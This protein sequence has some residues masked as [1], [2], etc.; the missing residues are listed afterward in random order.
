MDIQPEIQLI[1]WTLLPHFLREGIE[2]FPFDTTQSAQ[3]FSDLLIAR[4]QCIL[5]QAPSLNDSSITITKFVD[6][7]LTEMVNMDNESL[8]IIIHPFTYNIIII[9]TA[10]AKYA[11]ICFLN[12]FRITRPNF[13]LATYEILQSYDVP[14]NALQHLLQVDLCHGGEHDPTRPGP[15]R[16]PWNVKP[17]ELGWTSSLDDAL[18]T[19]NLNV[20]LQIY[21]LIF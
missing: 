1:D 14:N 12:N 17:H 8:S 3:I 11:G 19:F 15:V 21:L 13:Y 16:F 9:Q 18:T 5:L 10:G 6:M 2:S 20:C 7:L 4:I